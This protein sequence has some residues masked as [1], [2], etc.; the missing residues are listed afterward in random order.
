MQGEFHCDLHRDL[1][2]LYFTNIDHF[3]V[4]ELRRQL[5]GL[6][7]MH[8]V[9]LAGGKKAK[10]RRRT[11]HKQMEKLAARI[12]ALSSGAATVAAAPALRCRTCG[13]H[14]CDGNCWGFWA[15]TEPGKVELGT[16][17]H[18]PGTEILAAK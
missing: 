7:A 10:N 2:A 3:P 9:L 5:D 17:R 18:A 12:A 14:D 1:K 4:E 13:K 11:V 8:E 15:H 16:Q 6:T